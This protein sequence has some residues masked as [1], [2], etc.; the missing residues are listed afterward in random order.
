[1]KTAK[2]W[3]AAIAALTVGSS[4]LVPLAPVAA[5]SVSDA[6]AAIKENKSQSAKI[7]S[8]IETANTKVINLQAKVSAKNAEIK[9]AEAQIKETQADV[10]KMQAKI[11]E[12]QAEVAARKH[13]MAEQLVSLQ[14]QAGNAVTGNVYVD[15]LLKSDNLSDLIARGVAVNK[16]NRANKSAMESVESAQ[17]Q[18]T[19]M[20]TKREAA[21][22]LMKVTKQQL[23]DDKQALVKL[24]DQA[25]TQSDNLND[26][27]ADNQDVLA[28]LEKKFNDATAAALAAKKAAKEAA[29]KKKASA[30]STA[31]KANSS[32]SSSTGTLGGATGVSY[33]SA[34][35]TYPWGQCTWYAKA[36][37]GW[38]GNGWGNGNQW[39]ASAAA[40]GFTVNH[41]PAVGSIV[42]FGAGQMIGTWQADPVYGH[43]AYVESVSGNT[44]TISQGGMGFDNPAGPNM[45]TLSGAGN[46]TYIHP[47]G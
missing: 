19:S 42:S 16:L 25:K 22:S 27:L 39:G 20:K 12:Q 13:V 38:A 4:T 2:V 18:L 31:D 5:D 1:M 9:K 34:G 21:L 41:T 43:V 32:T 37:S 29:A 47:K 30:K 35:N 7:L 46:F 23:V 40:Q 3:I 36:R 26:M 33:S 44:I 15:F 24:H 8:Q 6:K 45:Q 14:Q 10:N 11:K 28:D 17:A